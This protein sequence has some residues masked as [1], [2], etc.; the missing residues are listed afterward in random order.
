MLEEKNS[1]LTQLLSQDKASLDFFASLSPDLRKSLMKSDIS[2]FEHLKNC[3]D[4]YGV[5]QDYLEEEMLNYYNPACSACDCTGLI[6]KGENQNTSE[7][8][9]YKKIENFG[10]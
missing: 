1:S 3:S 10:V 7:I 6:P 2:L 9:N 8:D 5:S 4:K